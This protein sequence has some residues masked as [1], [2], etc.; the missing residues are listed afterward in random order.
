MP[1]RLAKA[2]IALKLS[3]RIGAD[4]IYQSGW[5]NAGKPV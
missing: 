4:V 2:C 5:L 1:V 3:G